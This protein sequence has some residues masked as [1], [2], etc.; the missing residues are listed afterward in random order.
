MKWLRLAVA[1]KRTAHK[2]KVWHEILQDVNFKKG[3][4]GSIGWGGM[5]RGLW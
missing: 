5:G 1:G 4:L 3:V 2:R